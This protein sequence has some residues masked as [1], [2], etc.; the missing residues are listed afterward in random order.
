MPKLSDHV[1]HV[2]DKSTILRY[3]LWKWAEKTAL[4]KALLLLY[5]LNLRKSLDID[6]CKIE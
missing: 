2:K 5:R 3:I 1:N 6:L 4:V